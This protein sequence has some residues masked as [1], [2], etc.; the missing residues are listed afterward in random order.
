MPLESAVTRAVISFQH[1]TGSQSAFF[2]HLPVSRSPIAT[3]WL[4]KHDFANVPCLYDRFLPESSALEYSCRDA[5]EIGRSA[6]WSPHTASSGAEGACGR[7]LAWPPGSPRRP[8]RGVATSVAPGYLWRHGH[9]GVSPRMMTRMGGYEISRGDYLGQGRGSWFHGY[10]FVVPID[11]SVFI[12]V[13]FPISIW[14]LIGINLLFLQIIGTR[15]CQWSIV[16]NTE[17]WWNTWF[18]SLNSIS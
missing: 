2:R 12:P 15:G 5:P 8:C 16:L 4:L 10:W 11:I 6:I 1:R 9:W 13:F 18:T 17:F 7:G 3:L 14:D